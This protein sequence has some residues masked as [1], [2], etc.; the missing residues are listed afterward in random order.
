ML[1]DMQCEVYEVMYYG[2][3]SIV[4]RDAKSESTPTLNT[5]VRALVGFAPNKTRMVQARLFKAR[6]KTNPLHLQLN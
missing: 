6:T 5:T 2:T 3:I 1:C 4:L